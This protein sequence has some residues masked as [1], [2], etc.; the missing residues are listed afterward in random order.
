MY[1]YNVSIRQNSITSSEDNTPKP[2]FSLTFHSAAVTMKIRSRSPKSN[3]LVRPSQKI[4]HGKEAFGFGGHNNSVT[5]L[6][7][8]TGNNPNPDLVNINAYIQNM[9]KFCPLVLKISSAYKIITSIKG[10]NSV[11]NLRKMTGNNCNLDLV[12]VNA[13][14]IW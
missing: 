12:K 13:Y 6:R 14:K 1:L 4:M 10:H 3:Q 5:N 7:K 8:R 9:M 11:T 2:Y